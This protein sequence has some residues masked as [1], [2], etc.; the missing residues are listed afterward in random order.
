MASGQLVGAIGGDEQ[1]RRVGQGA[2]EEA[3]QMAGRLVRPVDVL[4][5]QHQRGPRARVLEQP[6]DGL[7]QLEPDGVTRFR[8]RHEARQQHAQRCAARSGP[9]QDLISSV[10]REQ[11][12]QRPDDRRVRQALAA[13]R[14]ALALDDLSVAARERRG[15]LRGEQLQRASSCPL[16]PR[17]RS[18]RGGSGRRPPRP[19]RRPARRPGLSARRRRP[20]VGRTD[21]RL[22]PC[23]PSCHRG[24]TSS[25]PFS[26]HRAGTVQCA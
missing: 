5:H 15:E 25:A 4:D 3:E 19:A 23:L 11:A 24:P 10:E 13:E 14:H 6:R 8:A 9:L 2:G 7:E 26:A 21:G 18:G 22:G 16:R 20:V 1:H 17:R 12:A